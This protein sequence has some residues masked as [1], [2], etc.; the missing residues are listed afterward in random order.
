MLYRL[1]MQ[2]QPGSAAVRETARRRI[3]NQWEI[4]T[5]GNQLAINRLR[6]TQDRAGKTYPFDRLRAGSQ[7]LKPS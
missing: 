6:N 2:R 1:R 3:I 7:G 5:E 4:D